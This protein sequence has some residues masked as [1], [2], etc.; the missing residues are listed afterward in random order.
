M[1]WKL[2][3]QTHDNL[4]QKSCARLSA[5]MSCTAC[6][7]NTGKLLTKELRKTVC[8]YVLHSLFPKHRQTY[9]KRAAQDCLHICLAQLASKQGKLNIS[10]I[11]PSLLPACLCGEQSSKGSS[12]DISMCKQ[13]AFKL[14]GWLSRQG[15]VKRIFVSVE[16]HQRGWRCRCYGS[17]ILQG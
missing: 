15:K 16:A 7:Q 8:T 9:C 5:L 3:F 17:E 6:F 13:A 11:E 4:L 2:S 10:S 1:S 12:A 14:M